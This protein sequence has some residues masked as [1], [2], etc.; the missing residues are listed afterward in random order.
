MPKA[1]IPHRRGHEEAEGSLH[2][3]N[4]AQEEGNLISPFQMQARR[5]PSRRR[6]VEKAT[7]QCVQGPGLASW[8]LGE[9]LHRQATGFQ[10]I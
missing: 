8:G 1:R 2:S 5:I 6:Y 3:Q 7:N 9:Q 4:P 10:I